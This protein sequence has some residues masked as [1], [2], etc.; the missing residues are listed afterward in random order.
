MIVLGVSAFFH[1]SAVC[2]VNENGIMFACQEERY[3][4]QKHDASFPINALKAGLRYL[5]LQAEDVS[6]IAFYENPTKKI[7]RTIKNFSYAKIRD[8]DF[9]S[10][11]I[12]NYQSE[13]SIKKVF[14]NALTPLGFSPH[15]IN[16]L[17]FHDH[18]LS[19]AASAFFPS[20]LGD[21]AIITIDGVGELETTQIFE[22]KHNSIKSLYAIQYPHSLG[23]LYSAFTQLLGF[24]VNSGEYKVMGLA[25]YGEPRFVDKI[26]SNIV[27]TRHDGSFWLNMDYF[28]FMSGR[29]MVSPLLGNLFGVPHRS[30]E[31]NLE[32]VHMD[33]AASLQKVTEEIVVNIARFSR[34][35]TGLK[36]LCLAGGV[37]LN[38]VANGSLAKQKIFDN[39]WIQPASGDAGG[40]LGAAMLSLNNSSKISW[41]MSTSA[42]HEDHM[43]GS[44]LGE[45]FSEV[46][47]ESELLANNA[48]FHHMTDKKLLQSVV[49]NLVDGKVIGW[50]KGRAEFGPRALGNR[51]IIADPRSEKMQSKLNLKIKFRESFRPFAPIVI[52]DE[53]DHWFDVPSKNPYML[54][55]GSI[56]NNLR[57]PLKKARNFREKINASRSTL[58]AITHVDY[59]ARVQAISKT[60]NPLFYDLLTDFKKETGVPVLV[61]TSFNVRGEPIVNSPLEAYKCFMGTGMDV[62]VVENYLLF[63]SEQNQE[64]LKEYHNYFD[65]D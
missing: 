41:D 64:N 14:Y 51:S 29:E 50:F 16:D 22:G 43:K 63:K 54:M 36:N 12:H 17:D 3:T 7:N 26:K 58:P 30:S 55:V 47:V 13:T 52:E 45:G 48:I 44:F 35:E 49:S 62:L 24:K 15:V 46:Q 8:F 1:D 10:E 20:R 25:P 11:F 5:N 38:C 61:N 31:S 9:F 27:E 65:M 18:H 21:A 37:A 33:I 53:A 6:K 34:Q 23:L 57:K 28:K 2:F 40:A 19:H 56:K 32:Q 39:I 42:V 59:S 60:F 4:R